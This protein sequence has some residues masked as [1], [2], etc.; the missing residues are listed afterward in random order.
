MDPTVV[1]S[2]P[3]VIKEEA[4]FWPR[5]ALMS[6]RQ[7]VVIMQATVNAEGRVEAVTVLRADHEG[8]GI[9]QAAKEAALKYLSLIHI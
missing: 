4:V 6:R 1:D 9:P 7:G 2:L 8:F 5:A 3:V